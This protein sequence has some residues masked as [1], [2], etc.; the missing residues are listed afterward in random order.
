MSVSICVCVW[1]FSM[2]LTASLSLSLSA[3][4]GFATYLSHLHLKTCVLP[5]SNKAKP[6]DT[7]GLYATVKVP[8]INWGEQEKKLELIHV[9]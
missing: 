4:K 7:V 9:L 2:Y 8:I 6:G 3:L 1:L 5:A